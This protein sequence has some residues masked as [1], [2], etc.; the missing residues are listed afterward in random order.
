VEFRQ[1]GNYVSKEDLIEWINII[2][3][4]KKYAYRIS[5]SNIVEHYSALGSDQFLA[6]IFDENLINSITYENIGADLVDGMR[7]AQD[8]FSYSSSNLYNL[9]EN[10]VSVTEGSLADKVCAKL[11]GLE[12]EEEKKKKSAVKKKPRLKKKI[13]RPEP[14]AA[15]WINEGARDA[16]RYAV[17]PAEL[18][19][20]NNPII[21]DDE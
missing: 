20:P 10:Y 8:I 2:M 18:F 19:N 3:S 15:M 12:D 14:G 5:P 4:I 17:D 16:A 6:E 9:N 11:S 1:Y 13:N 21:G 7:I